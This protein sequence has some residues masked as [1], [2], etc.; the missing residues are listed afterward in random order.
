ML[1]FLIVIFPDQEVIVNCF[2]MSAL[3]AI[4]IYDGPDN[5]AGIVGASIDLKCKLPHGTCQ[6]MYWTRAE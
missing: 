3:Y 5:V 1:L 6:D 4:N 2:I